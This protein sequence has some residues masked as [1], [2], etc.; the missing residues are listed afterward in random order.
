MIDLKNITFKATKSRGPGGQNVNKVNSAALMLWSFELSDVLSEEKK[1][2]IRLKLKDII[3]KEGE[4]YI[5]SDEFRDLERN[6]ERS[7][8]KLREI[9]K[10]AFH[11]PKARRKTKPT[12]SS[13]NKRITT[14]KNRGETKKGRQKV[15]F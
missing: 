2:I 10:K 1:Q 11:K 8:Q 14:K 6:K 7:L 5:R 13:V 12:F 15:S 3:N 4:V 9:L